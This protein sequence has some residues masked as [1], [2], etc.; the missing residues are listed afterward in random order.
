[1]DRLERHPGGDDYHR[2][3]IN[4]ANPG[5]I[6]LAGDQGAAVT[7]NGGRTWSSWYNQPTAQLYHVS[8]DNAFPYNVYGGQQESGSVCI[9]SRSNDGQITEREWHPVGAEEWGYV[10]A[11]PLNSNIVYGGKLSKYN[12]IT[13]QIQDISPD[14]HNG[15]YRFLRTAPLVFSPTDNKTL[16]YAGNVIFKTTDGGDTWEVISPD[17]TRT[18][19]TIPPSIGVYF[20]DTMNY[21]K[22]RGVVYTIA[23]SQLDP[24]L[25]WAGTD[26]GLMQLTHDGGRNWG[27]VTPP[28]ITGWNKISMLEASHF[29]VYTAYAAVNCIR[30]DDEHPHIFRTRDGGKT[31]KQI[32]NGL[33][34]APINT[35]KEDP[36]CK[37]LLFA[38]SETA[39]YV[40]FDDGDHWQ[41][42]R[43]NMPASSIRD[44]AIKDNDLIAATHGR[45]FW[46]LDDITPL[47]QISEIHTMPVILYKP[48]PAYRIRWDMWPDTPLPPD[49][50]AGKNPPDG[51]VIDYYLNKNSKDTVTLDIL[52]SAGNLVRRYTSKDSMYKIPAVNIPLYWIRPRQILSADS[53]SHR[54]LWDMHYTHLN[55]PPAYPISAVVGQT[56][57]AATSPWVMP[58]TYTV[59][60]T[61]NGK[62]FTQPLVVEMDPRVKTSTD[63]LLQQH[64]L[65]MLC[66]HDEQKIFPLLQTISSLQE[67][68]YAI[69]DKIAR[70]INQ[71]LLRN[72]ID[73]CF[74]K[75]GALHHAISDPSADGKISLIDDI[76]NMF[77]NLEGAD[78]Q[79]PAQYI[80]ETNICHAKFEK[81]WQF[82][83]VMQQELNQLNS[84]LQAQ[85]LPQVKWNER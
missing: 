29:D 68:L 74:F 79:P 34:D 82:W 65:S 10:V 70:G 2:L 57:P 58:G 6:L 76:Q 18:S 78:S 33:P 43:L 26:D 77:T 17:L 56:A 23:L 27:N 15:R 1:M 7:V 54:F 55:T 72:K 30:L 84:N 20:N 40:S 36:L 48:E 4:P 47:R 67:Q 12:K 53:G 41:S 63:A 50:P 39:V 38:G 46:I 60:L 62:S 42:L 66:Y 24:N 35:V 37:G 49:E 11:D 3:W 51:A 81:L 19:Y 45:S 64:N 44:L 16:Y 13:G 80:A 32:V 25:I 8:A 85:H 22:P 75:L 71:D 28:A 69:P 61:V 5:I 73:T 21:M 83:G 9:A 52:D 14:C 59:K 31:W